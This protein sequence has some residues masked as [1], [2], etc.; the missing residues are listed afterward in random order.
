MMIT[1]GIALE[2]TQSAEFVHFLF[3]IMV[4]EVFISCHSIKSP[5]NRY[6]LLELLLLFQASPDGVPG[7]RRPLAAA[8]ERVNRDHRVDYRAIQLLLEFGASPSSLSLARD[9]TPMHAA[10]RIGLEHEKG[11]VG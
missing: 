4:T 2:T 7:G 8:V 9:D 11:T 5:R 6:S 1:F 3:L 10:A